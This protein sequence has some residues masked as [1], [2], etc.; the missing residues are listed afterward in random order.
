[1]AEARLDIFWY[2]CVLYME[3]NFSSYFFADEL[4]NVFFCGWNSVYLKIPINFHSHIVTHAIYK[5]YCIRK[6]NISNCAHTNRHKLICINTQI[7]IHFHIDLSRHLSFS[8]S[9]A[10]IHWLLAI[11]FHNDVIILYKIELDAED[12][13]CLHYHHRSF[14][15]HL[16]T[17]WMVVSFFKTT[18][19]KC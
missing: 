16:A 19:W 13:K 17:K 11:N 6:K 5:I 8:P 18:A 3:R 14:Y 4:D 12:W 1:M 15:R 7:L 2:E 9:F 10:L